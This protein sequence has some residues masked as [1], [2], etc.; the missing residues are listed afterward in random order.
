MTMTPSLMAEELDYVVDNPH[1]NNLQRIFE[2]ARA[3]FGRIDYGFSE[4]RLVT[5]EI[6][7]NPT[8]PTGKMRLG[9]HERKA[10]ILPRLISA[11]MAI[12][13]DPTSRGQIELPH[14]ISRNPGG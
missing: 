9:R 6:N 11:F 1:E 5:F 14:F 12:D 8:F 2:L 10:I 13:R 4:G 3:D 7:S